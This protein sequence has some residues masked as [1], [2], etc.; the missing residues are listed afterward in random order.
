[1][2]HQAARRSWELSRCSAASCSWLSGSVWKSSDRIRYER[3]VERQKPDPAPPQTLGGN[4]SMGLGVVLLSR[5]WESCL[6]FRDVSR[7]LGEAG[8]KAEAAMQR[9]AS[10]EARS[11]NET[12]IPPPFL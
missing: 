11:E 1:M 8:S 9:D 12:L 10:G 2:S 7:Q 3:D 5:A 6:A 4:L